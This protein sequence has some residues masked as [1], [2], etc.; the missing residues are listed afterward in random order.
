MRYQKILLASAAVLTLAA[1][2][3]PAQAQVVRACYSIAN[4]S[5]RI[6]SSAA[7]CRGGEV[8]TTWSVTGPQGPAGPAGPTGATG[9]AGAVGATGAQGPIG[10][11]GPQGP[12][13]AA[14]ATGAQGLPGADGAVGPQGPAGP[15]GPAG[16][17]GATGAT[18]AQ[19]LP[20]ADGATGA[21]GAA[22]AQGPQGL[23]G[24]TGATG[25]T[26]AQGPQGLTGAT[27]AQGPQG[28]KG[29]T[30]P[31][32]IQGTQGP[33]GPQGPAGAGLTSTVYTVLNGGTYGGGY[34][35]INTASN[36]ASLLLTCNYGVQGDNEI[37]WFANDPSVT[38][39]SIRT[40]NAVNGQ[41]VQAFN[42]LAYGSGGQDRGFPSTG[43][44]GAWPYHAVF[45]AVE[46]STVSRFEVTVAGAANQACTFVVSAVNAGSIFVVRP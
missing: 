1:S 12:V 44:S 27:G 36:R 34:L 23:K 22:G 29:D 24:D 40:F 5:V 16:P 15:I 46:G 2:A 10:P 20:G 7:D 35:N 25:A 41:P 6:V 14:G 42:D 28:L 38:A 9:A 8:F 18:G 3:V 21:T 13:G 37:L 26:G 43:G 17:A 11:A 45:I 31:Q 33:A 19:G 32:G 39:G 30:G 4:G